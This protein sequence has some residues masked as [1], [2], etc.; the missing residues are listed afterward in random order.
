ME[1]LVSKI[2]ASDGCV[3]AL[4]L[5]LS[6]LHFMV[7]RLVVIASFN[8][9]FSCAFLFFST[10]IH[11]FFFRFHIQTIYAPDATTF[12]PVHSAL[13][14]HDRWHS[15][16]YAFVDCDAAFR[17]DDDEND[18]FRRHLRHNSRIRSPF[19]SDRF[20]AFLRDEDS[21]DRI[22]SIII[23]S[24]SSSIRFSYDA[25]LFQSTLEL[26][27]CLLQPLLIFLFT[28]FLNIFSFLLV[29]F[30]RPSF[31]LLRHLGNAASISAAIT[32]AATAIRHRR[33]LLWQFRTRRRG[34]RFGI[35]RVFGGATAANCRVGSCVG[36]GRRYR[37][38]RDHLRSCFCNH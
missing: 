29:L 31:S 24:S 16:S 5:R 38:C 10:H 8:F 37:P 25:E 4:V 13:N 18:I 11:T 22:C 35:S 12:I 23:S 21:F 17:N 7:R 6:S 32:A 36:I 26:R 30:L 20:H 15:L 1:I 3:S 27:S 9:R 19:V 28:F 14:Q 34:R 33:W 2:T